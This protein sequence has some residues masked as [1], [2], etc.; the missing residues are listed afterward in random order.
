MVYFIN[1]SVYVFEIMLLNCGKAV[2]KPRQRYLLL[3]LPSRA[4]GV[5]PPPAGL[6]LY[7]NNN[8][9]ILVVDNNPKAVFFKFSVKAFMR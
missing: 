6:F 1:E 8:K 3:R 9:I 2:R 7:L 4:G 5:S